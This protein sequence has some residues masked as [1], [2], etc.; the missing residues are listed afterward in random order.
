MYEKPLRSKGTKRFWFAAIENTIFRKQ[1]R[2]KYIYIYILLFSQILKRKI[3]T[4]GVGGSIGRVIQGRK[5]AALR[6]VRKDMTHWRWK[7]EQGKG[8]PLHY[9]GVSPAGRY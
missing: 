4:L 8:K 7:Q 1:I 6:S 3:L 9:P 2:L 5:R